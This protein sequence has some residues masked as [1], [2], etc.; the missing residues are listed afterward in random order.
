MRWTLSVWKR[1]G[2]PLFYYCCSFSIKT[3]TNIS[4]KSNSQPRCCDIHSL[5]PCEHIETHK[6]NHRVCHHKPRIALR[7][8]ASWN[9]NTWVFPNL[10]AVK[11]RT[12]IDIFLHNTKKKPSHTIYMSASCPLPPSERECKTARYTQNPFRHEIPCQFLEEYL[13]PNT[14]NASRGKV[15]D[16][17]TRIRSWN[18]C[19][20][21]MIL[22]TPYCITTHLPIS[23][24]YTWIQ[25]AHTKNTLLQNLLILQREWWYAYCPP[26]ESI[27]QYQNGPRRRN[28]QEKRVTWPKTEK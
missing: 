20:P 23:R 22:D 24:E 12:N 25:Q 14:K 17:L 5:R 28:V 26:R 15:V 2:T 11:T 7:S 27:E 9:Q 18:N 8:T 21:L 13:H 1:N 6:S 4:S 16:T 3:C 19:T 10:S